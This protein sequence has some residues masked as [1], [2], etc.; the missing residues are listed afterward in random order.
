MQKMLQ[1][2]IDAG[3]EVPDVKAKAVTDFD[4]AKA[5]IDTLP[6]ARPVAEFFGGDI[7]K[8]L[9]RLALLHCRLER[10]QFR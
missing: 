6:T 2:R 3:V 4:I 10:Q 9:V 7:L 8:P 5:Y 1:A